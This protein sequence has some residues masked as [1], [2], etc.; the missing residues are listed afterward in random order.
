MSSR[1]SVKNTATG[2]TAAMSA[3][4][5][6]RFHD[7]W[8]MPRSDCSPAVRGRTASHATSTMDRDG[9]AGQP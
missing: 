4:A 9:N 5:H 1:C 7:V 8:Y 6:T 2:A 3:P